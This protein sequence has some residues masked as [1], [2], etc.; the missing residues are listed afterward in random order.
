M[1]TSR[2]ST[3]VDAFE[4][5]KE[6]EYTTVPSCRIDSETNLLETALTQQGTWLT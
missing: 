5:E 3:D 4:K 1:R 2:K 6:N